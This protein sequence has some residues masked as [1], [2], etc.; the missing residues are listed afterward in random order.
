MKNRRKAQP[1]DV[2]QGRESIG[3]THTQDHESFGVAQDHELVE[4]L[5]E[6]PV[7]RGAGH[8]VQGSNFKNLM[9]EC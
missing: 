1:F 7:E 5:V 3:I 4:W 8:K 9:A 6:W 2:V